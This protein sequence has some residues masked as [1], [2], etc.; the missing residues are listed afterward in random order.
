MTHRYKQRWCYVYYDVFRVVKSSWCTYK[1]S[2]SSRAHAFFLQPR[3]GSP[4]VTIRT[5]ARIVTVVVNRSKFSRFVYIYFFIFFFQFHARVVRLVRTRGP[6]SEKLAP[7]PGSTY[8]NT[9]I[10]RYKKKKKKK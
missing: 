7:S 5:R 9:R 3:V 6:T 10:N 2:S 1:S 8:Y 4:R